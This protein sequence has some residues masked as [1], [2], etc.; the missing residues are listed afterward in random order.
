MESCGLIQQIRP[1]N[2]LKIPRYSGREFGDMQLPGISRNSQTGIRSCRG[3]IC[4][5]INNKHYMI[6]ID[7]SVLARLS[8]S[9]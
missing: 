4:R 2:F 1:I 9:K 8:C 6:I 3:P 7:E 5:C